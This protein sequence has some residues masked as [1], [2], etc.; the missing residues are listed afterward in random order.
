MVFKNDCSQATAMNETSILATLSKHLSE[1][2]VLSHDAY[3]DADTRLAMT[4][5]MLVEEQHFSWKYS[6]V[7]DVAHKALA[8]NLSDLAATGAHPR[9]VLV[10]LGLPNS[11]SVETIDTFYATLAE[12][13]KQ[14]HCQI[15]GGDT[16]GSPRWVIN[17]TA[18][19]ELPNGH[20]AGR[21]SFAKPGDKVI[22]TG[23]HGLSATG[24]WALENC[25]DGFEVSKA[26][27]RRPTPYVEAGLWLSQHYSRY[28]LMDSSD[29]LADVA[30]K[31]SG[32]SGVGLVLDESKFDVHPELAQWQEQT[33]KPVIEP[34][35]Y[36]GEDFHLVACVPECLPGWENYFQ[37]IGEVEALR[38]DTSLP[39]AWLERNGQ[40]AP[41]NPKACFQH[42]NE[43]SP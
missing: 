9:W 8:V 23:P 3:F 6:S 38:V 22:T 39:S 13:C 21:R 24:L 5:D 42:F 34:L 30:I 35:L 10:S 1:P 19:G 14:Y 43:A 31:L 26:V 7:A 4:T 36:G 40:R 41:L 15:V 27:H 25:V 20:T 37:V 17:I 11:V 12:L 18:I 28:A 32:A 2:S 29:G 33:Q 16:V